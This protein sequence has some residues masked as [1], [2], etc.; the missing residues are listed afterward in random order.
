MSA[1]DDL[2]NVH[3]IVSLSER[4][5]EETCSRC[6][7]QLPRLYNQRQLLLANRQKRLAREAKQ[8]D[9]LTKLYRSL[10]LVQPGE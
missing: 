5:F 7:E 6:Q 10:G 4:V 3:L 2:C 9:E 8:R 1:S